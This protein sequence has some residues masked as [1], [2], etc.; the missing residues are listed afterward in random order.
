MWGHFNLYQKS[1]IIRLIFQI[2]YEFVVLKIGVRVFETKQ[3]EILIR[4]FFKSQ[5]L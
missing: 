1:N 3:V 5:E 2:K 4:H